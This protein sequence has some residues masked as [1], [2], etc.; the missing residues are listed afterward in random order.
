MPKYS[1][2]L[3]PIFMRKYLSWLQPTDAE[4]V[5]LR[6]YIVGKKIQGKGIPREEWEERNPMKNENRKM[7]RGKKEL[8]RGLIRQECGRVWDNVKIP[9]S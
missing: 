7:L 9:Q 3:S 4:E 2:S 1:P 6:R 8:W 5:L